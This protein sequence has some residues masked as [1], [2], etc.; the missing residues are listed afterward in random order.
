[1]GWLST[2]SKCGA[3]SSEGLGGPHISFVSPAALATCG[4]EAEA[5]RIPVC[6]ALRGDPAPKSVPIVRLL[7]GAGAPPWPAEVS[8]PWAQ[9]S[10]P[11]M[12][13]LPFLLHKHT[14]TLHTGARTLQRKRHR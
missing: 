9:G 4:E 6:V 2:D 5:P 7:A 1:M 10:P 13:C 14:G 3:G 12:A 11:G 8:G